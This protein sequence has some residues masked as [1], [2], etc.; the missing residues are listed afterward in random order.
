VVVRLTAVYSYEWMGRRRAGLISLSLL[1]ECSRIA[2]ATSIGC[3][4]RVLDRLW[5]RTSSFM[6]LWFIFMLLRLPICRVLDFIFYGCIYELMTW[7]LWGVCYISAVMLYLKILCM[8]IESYSKTWRLFLNYLL[9]S[10]DLL[11]R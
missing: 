5:S 6:L 3:L 11:L 10:R 1:G 4:F 9:Y 8:S 2:G 7:L